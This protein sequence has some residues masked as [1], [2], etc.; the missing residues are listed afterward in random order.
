[1]FNLYMLLVGNRPDFDAFGGIVSLQDY[2]TVNVSAN[3]KINDRWEAFARI[4]NLTDTDYEEVFAF[5]TPGISGYA[6]VNF[7]W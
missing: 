6:G 4:D 2:I 7:I 1:M 5:A 3:H